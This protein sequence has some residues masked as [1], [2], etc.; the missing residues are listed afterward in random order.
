MLTRRGLTI[1]GAL[2]LC[3]SS[4]GIAQAQN[5]SKAQAALTETLAKAKSEDCASALQVMATLIAMP[6]FKRFDD[7]L[8]AFTF[9][10]GLRCAVVLKQD[11][12][13][14]TYAVEGSKFDD[15]TSFVLRFRL[16]AEVFGGKGKPVWSGDDKQGH[17]LTI[18]GAGFYPPDIRRR[19][20]EQDQAVPWL[21]ADFPRFRCWATTIRLPISSPKWHWT[22]FADPVDVRLG[23]TSYWRA[24]GMNGNIVRTVMSRN[25]YQQEFS[26]AEARI[27]NDA[28]PTFN[29]KQSSIYQETGKPSTPAKRSILPFGDSEDWVGSA[30]ACSAPATR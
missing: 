22:L 25:V 12:V 14:Y 21:N 30:A 5:V 28:I 27:V 6:D 10:L 1:L 3:V 17:S 9:D 13:A 2:L 26:S 8:Q 16:Y 7:Q 4:A 20:P 24:S 18:M 29:N 11:N 15:A 23:G 19:A